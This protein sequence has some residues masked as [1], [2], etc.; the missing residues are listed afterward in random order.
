MSSSSPPQFSAAPE[1]RRY[2][3]LDQL[4]AVMMLLGL[5]IHSTVSFI[6]KPTEGWRYQDASTSVLFD[7]LVFFIHVFRM[8]LFFL[9]AG[10]FTAL[11]YYR[12]GAWEMLRNRGGR[13]AI[14][15]AL[16]LAVLFPLA[17]SGFLFTGGGGVNG[18]WD[19]ARAY[20]G[21]PAAWYVGLRTIHLW[22][23]YYLI[24]FYVLI[25]LAMPLAERVAGSWAY[26]LGSRLGTLIHHPLGVLIGTATTFLT[27]LPMRSAALDTETVF[28]VRPKILLAYGVFVGFG[29]VLYLN[30]QEL[31]RFAKRA[32][33]WMVVGVLLSCGYLGYMLSLKGEYLLAGNGGRALAAAAMWT[34]IY[35]FIGLF[36]RYYDHP[37]P[38]GRY[39]ADASYWVFLIHLPLTIWV[40]GLMNG[41]NV[42][43]IVKSAITLT[44]T[45]FVAVATYDLFVRSTAIGAVLNG[46]RHSR[47]L[48]GV[49]VS[50]ARVADSASSVVGVS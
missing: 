15:F 39:L 17:Q 28:L 23:L 11:L 32:W 44:V 35:G 20:L 41:W 21:N 5:V 22:F 48:P 25:A 13:V 36:L 46:K 34:L 14:P 49:A 33:L 9:M 38:V 45:T 19:A 50:S 4:R 16:S 7:I 26:G 10:F 27:L 47:G 3:A 1:D 30:R 2:H 37:K 40:P 12:R 42:H 43:A 31:D 6:T 29:W 24:L 8:P 18:G